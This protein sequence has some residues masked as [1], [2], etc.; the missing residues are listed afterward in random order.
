MVLGSGPRSGS[1]L[2]LGSGPM[3]G[4]YLG[5]GSGPRLGSFIWYWVQVQGHGHT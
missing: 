1:Y 2:G 4:S 5:L 3:S